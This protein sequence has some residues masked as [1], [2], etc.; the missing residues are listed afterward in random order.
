MITYVFEVFILFSS[1]TGG[2]GGG[3][4]GG[5]GRAFK[6]CPSLYYQFYAMQIGMGS[7]TVNLVI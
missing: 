1:P 2:G 5:L 6:V 7:S 4:G 3:G